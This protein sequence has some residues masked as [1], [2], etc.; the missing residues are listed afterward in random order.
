MAVDKIARLGIEISTKDVN[1]AIA[2]LD[3][4]ENQGK[5]TEKATNRMS[6]AFGG[7]QTAIGALGV[8]LLV[9][10]TI[11]LVNTYKG[12]ENRLKLVT[13]SAEN[14]ANIQ[15]R[16]FQIAQDTRGPLEGTVDLYTRLARSTQALG[17]SQNELLGVTETINKAMTI[18]GAS[19][20]EASAALLQLGQGLAS[21]TL[22]G[23]ELN[24]VLEQGPRLAQALA[25][26]LGITVGQLRAMGAQGEITAEKVIGALQSQ[27]KA[28]D[29]E[30]GR[31][32]QTV[33]QA[34]QAMENVALKTFGSL[35]AKPLV[36]A[37]NEFS[38]A[39][40]DPKITSGLQSLGTG[41][42]KLAEYAV[43]AASGFAE[44]SK[45]IG[46]LAGEALY[47]PIN[48]EAT[49]AKALVLSQE[50]K[51]KSLSSTIDAY[52]KNRDALEQS[53]GSKEQ[54]AV[55]DTMIS[56]QE[57][58]LDR[59][60]RRL[61]L[62]KGINTEQQ[63]Q[64][65]KKPEAAQA[66][67]TA[68]SDF[69]AQQEQDKQMEQLLREAEFQEQQLAQMADYNAQKLQQQ[70]DYYDNL[71]DLQA[72]AQQ[73]ALQF[74]DAVRTA[75]YKG[76]LQHGALMLANVSKQSKTMF[77]VQKAFAL[78]NAAVALPDAVLQSF[79]NGG[80]YPWGLIPAGLMLAQGL[81]QI[82]AIRSASFGGGAP[83]GSVGGG[84]GG[85]SPSAP[86]ASGLPNGSTATPQGTEQP[87]P[88]EIRVTVE[89]DGPHSDGM[90]KFAQNLA[91]TIKDMGGVGSLVIS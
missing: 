34:F 63:T 37:I 53:G 89:G 87:A 13:T 22:R 78:A 76:A 3:K 38:N 60:Q 30:F 44:L 80:G 8:G 28:I 27:A 48:K 61:D 10:K 79:R 67:P 50:E 68:T 39:I 72:G 21:G 90:R 19:A 9:K 85:T 11:D 31:T 62:L 16:L 84:G 70:Q 64:A 52:K 58:L 91:E 7:L 43:K 35:D 33:D 45:K 75:D 47:G 51:V 69:A 26:G 82:N 74:T 24:S 29:T 20:Q 2:R 32:E 86:V 49:Q 18:S 66:A 46:E 4:L 54:I 71:Y 59:E 77:E 12:L 1:Q 55:F 36:A 40:S 6:R 83:S 88:K 25:D 65:I 56:Q 42:V 57:K 81:N 15:D 41:L 23:D 5:K 17:L 73:A 14:L